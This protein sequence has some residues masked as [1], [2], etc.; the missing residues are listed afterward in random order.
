MRRPVRLALVATVAIGAGALIGLLAGPSLERRGDRAVVPVHVSR[1]P[2]VTPAVSKPQALP[3]AAVVPRAVVPPPPTW[4]RNAVATLV[5]ADRKL[6]AIVID[7]VGVDRTIS[8][9]AV[10]LPAP[11]TLAFLP[12]ARNF[13][14]QMAAARERGHE[15]L[16]H[17]PMQPIGIED[18]GPGA[19]TLALGAVEI[20]RRMA[21]ALDRADLAVGINNHMGSRFTVER[22]AMH[23]VLDELKARGMLFL[24]SRTPGATVGPAMADDMAVPYAVRDVFLDNDPSIDAVRARLAE[25]EAAA[26]RQGY[27]VAIGHPHDGT[28][29]ALESWLQGVG[30]RGFA[31]VPISAIVR[32]QLDKRRGDPS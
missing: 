28:L 11:L 30:G 23:P 6:I 27:A 1:L 2:A 3:V 31:L 21:A 32:L 7:D 5:P 4:V 17:V 18:P 25:T 10:A 26:R 29:I 22:E 24:D 12:Y 9:R 16:V 13:E 20:R 15:I 19:L 14:S 8:N